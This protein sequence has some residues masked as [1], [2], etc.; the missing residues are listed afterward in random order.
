MTQPSFQGSKRG[1]DQRP[2]RKILAYRRKQRIGKKKKYNYIATMRSR[3]ESMR[4]LFWTL[5]VNL[6]CYEHRMA[7]GTAFGHLV[8]ISVDFV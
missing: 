3:T 5:V 7:Y 1:R 4:L 6:P 8:M 2:Y